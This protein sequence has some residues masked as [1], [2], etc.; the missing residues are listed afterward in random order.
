MTITPPTLREPFADGD[1]LLLDRAIGELRAGAD[2]W[3]SLSLRDRATLLRRTHATIHQHA[4]DWAALAVAAKATPP[5]LAGEEWLSGPYVVAA[6]TDK[7]AA[8]LE[9]LARGVSPASGL[10]TTLA[11]NGGTAVHVLPG[12]TKEG[13]LFHGFHGEIWTA[14]GIG[15][16][17]VVDDA[18][19]TARATDAPAGVGLVLGAGNISGIGVLDTLY[20]LVA[21]NRT[22]ILKLNPTF[23]SLRQVFERAF[24]PLVEAGLLRV[25]NGGAEAGAYLA[26]HAGID[27]VHIT[28][29]ASTHDAIVWGVGAAAEAN[30]AAGT[31]LLTKEISSELGGVSP[32]IVIPGEWSDAD[33]QFQAEHVAT[34]RLH[35]AGHNCIGT[36]LIIISSDWPQREAF[37]ERVRAVLATAGERAPW[38]PGSDRKL[39]AA[40]ASY[41][42]AESH[43]GRILIEV[44][45][46]ASEDLLTTEYFAP[47]LG[48]TTLP[49]TGADFF[50]A[51]V[52]FANERLYG[53]LGAS[54]IVKPSDR[55]AIGNRFDAILADL[56]YGNIG[57]NVWSAIAF[58]VPALPWGAFPGHTIADVG[59]GIGTVH[60]AHLIADVERSVVTGPF[61]PSP[62]SLL[63]GELAISPKPAWFIT[64]R[65]ADE[66]ARRLTRFEET[67]SW[68]RLVSV[69]ASAV[70]G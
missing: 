35:N 67:R 3:A 50:S 49:G 31:P 4:D 58:L 18:G 52:Q 2:Q 54:I 8:S 11:P 23:A 26:H 57:I 63:N 68:G 28:G 66:T 33:L 55:A 39:A 20:E 6:N 41:P 34:Q 27:H 15:A 40:R 44:D 9:Q 37:L 65:G 25:V 60:N 64:A 59:S 61:R 46:D 53:T 13:L 12:D 69:V 70:R 10:R 17:Q 38:Y 51:A 30:R 42:D 1:R 29:S 56:R 32:V 5:A 36:Q 48:Y 47:V 24:A 16:R 21:H 45:G 14:P 43:R 22:S 19:R 62:R 7:L